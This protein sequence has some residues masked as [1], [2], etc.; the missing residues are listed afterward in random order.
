MRTLSTVSFVLILLLGSPL[1][2]GNPATATDM[3]P[4]GKVYELRVYHTNPGKLDAL[5]A[6]FRDHTCTLFK[7]HGME[8]VGFWT[9]SEGDEAKDTLYYILAFP[10]VEAQKKAWQAFRADPQWIKAKADSE[11]EGVLVQKVESTN[12][13]ATDYSPMPVHSARTADTR[14][15]RMVYDMRI[16]K[17][18][19][20]KLDA[21]H[22]RFR[23]HTC[24]IF[25]KHG[26]ELIGFWTPSEGEEAKDTLI[27]IV[28]FPSVE[29][30]KRAW[31]AFWADPQWKKVKADSEKDGVL[32]KEIKGKNLKTTDYSPLQ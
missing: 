14:L 2:P 28:A 32:V 27:Y 8:L 20:G 24:Q 16:Y 6:R 26:M 18:N 3:P 9:P 17:T 19:P 29:A 22:A 1:L 25:Q 31:D 4:T 13:K 5:H 21:L 11:K 23:D 15:A 10:N 30:Q 12:L 7:K